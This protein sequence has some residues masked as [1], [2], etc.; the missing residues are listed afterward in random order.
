[1]T[2]VGLGLL[3]GCGGGSGA[4]GGDCDGGCW[5]P[6]A[7]DEQFIQSMC[8]LAASCCAQNRA[9]GPDAG[10]AGYAALCPMKLERS[11]ISR[12]ATLRSTCLSDL[13]RVA[14]TP[15]CLFDPSKL[16]SACVRL[17]YEP[18]GPQARGQ[19]CASSAD[20]S[21]RANAF[22][23]CTDRFNA[24]SACMTVSE[25]KLGDSCLGDVSELG[26]IQ[27]S[28]YLVNQGPNALQ[29]V[30]FYCPNSKGLRCYFDHED[31]SKLNVCQPIL[32]PGETCWSPRACSSGSCTDAQG[33]Q[34][35][36]S[37]PGTCGTPLAPKN[38]SVG[39]T[40]A[41]D[42]D[43]ASGNCASAAQTCS[44]ITGEEKLAELGLCTPL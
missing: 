25:G 43:C 19:P 3:V 13:Q 32:S 16:S 39:A 26:W 29:Y 12:D 11:G 38:L 9:N 10:V 35:E 22:T 41:G 4:G 23:T 20:C 24:S 6:S 17:I 18:S 37:T 30:G 7:A 36:G 8:A 14:G 1:M 34:V 40:C 21:G 31:P 2:A 44:A 27:V 42:E 33:G 15:N 28:P 5:H